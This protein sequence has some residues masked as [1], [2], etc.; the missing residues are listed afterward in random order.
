MI[1]ELK[2]AIVAHYGTITEFAN[3]AKWDRKKASRI[4][5]HV[6]APL[7]HD[8]ETMADLLDVKD[9]DTFVRLFLPHVSTKWNK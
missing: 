2:G 7:A 6:Q 4:A 3:A 5:N 1:N 9:G 8:M